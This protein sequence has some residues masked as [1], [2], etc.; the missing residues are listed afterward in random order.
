MKNIL[1]LIVS[2]FT[3]ASCEKSEVPTP[4]VINDNNPTSKYYLNWSC[5]S[6]NI[7]LKQAIP[8]EVKVYERYNSPYQDRIVFEDKEKAINIEF[9]YDY[10][11]GVILSR[12]MI[13]G[14]PFTMDVM[15]N[16]I[17]IEKGGQNIPIEYDLFSN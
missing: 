15:T 4:V 16:K 11:E 7:H 5:D 3:L 2:F 17:N 9:V 1:I 10:R 14:K 6:M 8:K 13:I 12:G